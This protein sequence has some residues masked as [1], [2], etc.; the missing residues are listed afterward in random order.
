MKNR[1]LALFTLILI[2]T[3]VAFFFQEKI[4]AY[5]AMPPAC[6]SCTTWNRVLS[7]DVGTNTNILYGVAAISPK[8]VWAVGSYAS[9]HRGLTLVEHWNGK[10]WN[11]VAS[12]NVGSGSNTL[13][14][15]AALSAQNVWAVGNSSDALG[16]A[17]TLI[18]HWNGKKWSIVAA[19]VSSSNSLSAISAISPT[20]I[21]AVG[22][23]I[24]HWNG[25]NWRIVPAPGVHRGFSGVATLASNNVWAVGNASSQGGAQTLIEHWNGKSWSVVRSSGPGLINELRGIT[26]ISANN[27]WAVGADT[28]S[29]T[30]HATSRSLIEHWNGKNWNMVPSPLQ[31]ISDQLLSV[32]V[33]SARDIWAVGYGTDIDPAGGLDFTLIEHWN[34]SAWHVVKSP[35]PG[36]FTNGL[37][38]VAHIPA[39]KSAWAV[40]FMQNENS[41]LQTLT[42]FHC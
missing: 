8:D 19:P 5:A 30:P 1:I 41:S 28:N 10:H 14:G 4:M 26:A 16:N 2:I 31:G 17:Q 3:L 34:G 23:L 36:S 42:T 21:W 24:E 40:G 39:T 9:G 32:G 7:P 6:H 27:I 37:L 15:V 33:T 13:L 12:P 11:V 18:E 29:F 38:S 20:D 35:N 25:K 22:S